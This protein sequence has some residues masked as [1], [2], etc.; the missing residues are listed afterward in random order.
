MKKI[1]LLFILLP[2]AA[3]ADAGDHSF[4]FMTNLAHLLAQPDHLIMLVC[5]AV[6]VIAARYLRK[7]GKL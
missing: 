3:F 4:G 5:G 7:A 1:T 6:L 2:A